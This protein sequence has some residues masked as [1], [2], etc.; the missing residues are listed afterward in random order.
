MAL[1]GICRN[2]I[3]MSYLNLDRYHHDPDPHRW[4][5]YVLFAGLLVTALLLRCWGAA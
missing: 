3:N 2:T 4:V 5:L 1:A